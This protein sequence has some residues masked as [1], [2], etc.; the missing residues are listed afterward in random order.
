MFNRGRPTPFHFNER[1]LS[2]ICSYTLESY[3]LKRIASIEGMPPLNVIYYW[4]KRYPCLR[5]Q[6]ALCKAQRKKFKEEKNLER[7]LESIHYLF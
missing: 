1:L 7:A 5:K 6:V 4:T 2:I 3:T